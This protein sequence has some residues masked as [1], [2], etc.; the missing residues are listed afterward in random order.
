MPSKRGGTISVRARH[1]ALR[2]GA[3]E[4]GLVEYSAQGVYDDD[5]SHKDAVYDGASDDGAATS[6][7][8]ETVVG[9][10]A[11]GAGPDNARKSTRAR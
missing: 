1:P 5:H 3:E 4:G 9:N 8:K 7:Q 11:S 2:A 6:T 10:K